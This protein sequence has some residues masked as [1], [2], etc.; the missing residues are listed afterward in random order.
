M[1][2]NEEG[3]FH[4]DRNS[5]LLTLASAL[6]YEACREY[7]L[8]VEGSRGRSSLSDITTVFISVSDVNDNAPVFGKGDYSTEVS[9]DISPGS[10]VMKVIATDADGPGNSL[11]RFSIV[12]GDSQQQFS[13]HPR[14]GDITVRTALDREQT[15]HYSLTVLAADEGSPPLSSALLV[16]VSV[17]DVNDNPPAFSAVNYN[18]TVQE[19]EAVGSTLLQLAVSDKDT[20]KNGPPFSFHIVSGN[21]DRRFQVDQGG[22]LSLSAPLRRKSRARHQ[23]KIQ[24]TDS[25]FP[26]LSSICV[27]NINV[28]ETSRFAPSAVPLD[29]FIT[30]T[31]ASFSNRAIGRIHASDQDL[32]DT[33]LYH[34]VSQNPP[35]SSFSVGLS[36]GKIW[37]QDSLQEGVYSLNVSVSDG[38]FV[39]FSGVKVHVW[40]A[41]QTALDGGVT[42]QFVGVGPEEF[43]G[44]HWRGVQRSLG[45]ALGLSRQEVH[46]VSLQQK[47]ESK[48]LEVLMVP[49]AKTEPAPALPISK[50]PVIISDMEDSLGLTIR[51]V[52][53]AGCAGP[54]CAPRGCRSSVRLTGGSVAHYTTARAGYITPQHVWESVCPC[55]ESALRFDG[56]GHLKY[57][58]GL[59]RIDRTSGCR[60][61]SE[62]LRT[63]ALLCSP[64]A[65]ATGEVYS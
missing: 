48:V 2:G 11:L 18:L 44:D 63:R 16:T 55:N 15:P 19:G 45:L 4:L 61:A 34:L 51:R 56:S 7:Y 60:C 28:T 3:V 20:P 32:H 17:S 64:T 6:D 50:L 21:E 59:E 30:T 41:R 47:A 33:L 58:P 57:L 46:L 31:T 8:S 24:V 52:T 39:V 5:G 27:V 43:I 14:T 13:I 36:D 42:L 38:K 9:E 37:A 1:S 40:A 10:L 22:L 29:I 35:E 25:G 53:H 62:R 49:R 23:L 65:P 12:S 54:G 26:P